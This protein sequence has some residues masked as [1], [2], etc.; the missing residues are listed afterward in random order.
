M[1]PLAVAVAA[2]VFGCAALSSPTGPELAAA[3]LPRYL[4]GVSF[5]YSDGTL[6]TAADASAERVTW[7][8]SQGNTSSG[9]PDFVFGRSQWQRGSRRG[10]RR[11]FPKETGSLWPLQKGNTVQYTETGTWV[12]AS[13]VEKSYRSRWVCSVMGTE[14][15]S[16]PAGRFDTW[17]IVCTRYTVAR[18]GGRSTEREQKIRY[19]APEIGHYVLTTRQYYGKRDARRMELVAVLPP[20][21]LL[22]PEARRY[23][24]TNF[25]EAM[26]H[27]PSGRS[28]SWFADNNSWGVVIIPRDTFRMPDGTF[29]RRYTQKLFLPEGERTYYGM[30]YRNAQ[31]RWG[32]PLHQPIRNL[33]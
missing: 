25:Q 14:R 22:E 6:E 23:V 11:F 9:T 26:E 33:K 13:G 15:V 12:D 3:P 30:A 32:L 24:E 27:R 29:Y 18:G 28:V 2:L 1:L 19:Y 4:K 17:K 21:D 20:L 5:L 8:D 10:T 31:G 16:V 7:T